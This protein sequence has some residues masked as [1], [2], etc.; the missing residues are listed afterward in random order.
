MMPSDERVRLHIHQRIAPLEHLAQGRMSPWPAGSALWRPDGIFADDR[1]RAE[2]S[3]RRPSDCAPPSGMSYRYWQMC[4]A[5][6]AT[7]ISFGELFS[8]V[9]KVTIYIRHG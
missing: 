3:V 9:T 7:L 1:H 8:Y 4:D 6:T 5:G 2:L